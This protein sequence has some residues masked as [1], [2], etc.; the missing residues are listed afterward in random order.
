M[1]G[2]KHRRK[3]K[4]TYLSS[5]DS[6]NPKLHQTINDKYTIND[7]CM[8]T[9][10]LFVKIIEDRNEQNQ[11]VTDVLSNCLLKQIIYGET[12]NILFEVSDNSKTKLYKEI[13][14][15][16]ILEKFEYKNRILKK[17]RF[18]YKSVKLNKYSELLIFLEDISEYAI[19][20]KMLLRGNKECIDFYNTTKIKIVNNL[21]PNEY[22]AKEK[23]RL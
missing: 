3:C 4:K 6:Y 2:N 11:E 9:T 12:G 23:K 20:K 7:K 8:L 5:V 19:L 16:L 17:L 18:S 13:L 10:Y 21:K 1:F 15:K 22:F 14:D